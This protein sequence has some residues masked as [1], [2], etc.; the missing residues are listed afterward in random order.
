MIQAIIEQAAH[1]AKVQFNVLD[2]VAGN[3]GN[4]STTGFKVRRFEQYIN[5]AGTVNGTTRVD[6]SQGTLMVT[7]RPLDIAIDGP[8]YIPVTQPDGQTAYTRDGR[9][10]INAQGYL[11]TMSGDI[12]GDGIQIS[13]GPE[14]YERLYIHPDGNVEVLKKGDSKATQ[15]GQLRLV[16]FTNPEG[17]QRG[18]KNKMLPTES[19]GKPQLAAIG[20]GGTIK[21]RT[22]EHANVSTFDQIGV[23][24]RLNASVISNMRIIKFSDELYRQAVNLKQ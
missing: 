19:S 14:G 20:D 12:V 17:L 13:K 6:T 7:D 15:V 18:G 8:G 11:V 5:E 23:T 1:N 4:M 10:A 24:M 16:T 2:H 3:I 22:L 9:L 21:Q